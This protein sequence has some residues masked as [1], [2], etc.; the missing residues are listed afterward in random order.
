MKQDPKEFYRSEE[1]NELSDF[2][3]NLLPIYSQ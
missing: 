2:L 1:S 3:G